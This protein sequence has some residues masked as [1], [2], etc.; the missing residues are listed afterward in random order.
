MPI[1]IQ[2]PSEFPLH[3]LSDRDGAI[4]LPSIQLVPT[5]GS[6]PYLYSLAIT[7]RGQPSELAA[8]IQEAYRGITR[9][10][11]PPKLLQKTWISPLNSFL[12][13]QPL[14][15]FRLGVNCTLQVSVEYC[16]SDRRGKPNQTVRNNIAKSCVLW[17]L[18][19]INSNNTESNEVFWEFVVEPEAERLET[20][21]KPTS[22]SLDEEV[23]KQHSLSNPIPPEPKLM[24]PSNPKEN[25]YPGFLAI[26]F[27]TSNSTV[28]LFDLKGFP[29]QDGLPKE[30]ENRLQER[31]HQWLNSAAA[32]IPGINANEWQKF[33][34]QISKMLEIDS[35]K[36]IDTVRD[37]NGNRIFLLETLRQ[38]ELCLPNYSEAFRRAVT[39]KISEIYAEAF[40]IPPLSSQTLFPVILN[41]IRKQKEICSELEIISWNS[42]PEIIMGER[43]KQDRRA[44]IAQVNDNSEPDEWKEIEGRFH[45]SPKRY[46][47]QDRSFEAIFNGEKQIISAN[48]L[49]QAT[50]GELIQLTEKYRQSKLK[51]FATGSF[52]TAVVTY[53]T[54]ASPLVRR[55]LEKIIKDLGLSD[56]ETV[57]D[58]A[59]AVAIFYLWREFGGNLNF[60]IESFKTRCHYDG[61]KWHQNLLAIDIGGGTTDI[62]LIRLTLKEIDPFEPHED[63]G[64]GGRYYV[65]TPKILGSSGHPQLGGELITLR[66]FRLLKVALADCLLTAQQEG[67]LKS[68]KLEN[69]IYELDERFLNGIQ[70]RIGSLL[71]C[72][73]KENPEGDAAYKDALNAAEKVIP[74]QWKDRPH[75]LQLFYAI[76]DMAEEIKLALGKHFKDQSPSAKYT[77]DEQKISEVLREIDQ[78]AEINNDEALRVTLHQQQFERIVTPVI[79]EAISIAK[80]LFE[81]R[82]S[83]S[84]LVNPNTPK[85][86]WLILSGQTSNLPQVQ[87]EIYSTFSQ[88]QYFVWNPERIAF[89]PEFAKLATSIGA[90]LAEKIRRYGFTSSNSKDMLIKGANQLDIEIKNLFYFLPCSFILRTQTED[91]PIT[92]FEAGKNLIQLDYEET[93]KARTKWMGIQLATSVYRLD[94]DRGERRNWGNFS[95]KGL[96]DALGMNGIDFRKYIQAQFEI[97]QKLQFKLF[98][99][100][101]NPHYLILNNIPALNG[102]SILKTLTQNKF[103]WKKPVDNTKRLP[104][105]GD[106]AVNVLEAYMVDAHDAYHLVFEAD[107]DVNQSLQI[108]HYEG[109]DRLG[110]GLISNPLPSFPKI[111]KHTFYLFQGGEWKLIGELS[112]PQMRTEFPYECRVTLDDKGILRIHAGEVPYCISDDRECLKE[113]GYVFVTELEL[114]PNEL[115]RER[116]PF[117][118]EH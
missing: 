27:G 59:V 114:Q 97:N 105:D 49:I 91:N 51:E 107:E 55:D 6:Q 96:A 15:Q 26:D 102:E 24:S 13:N 57:Y 40:R 45:H 7:V 53:P 117:S 66:L 39:K 85:I 36:L 47:G 50:Y 81:N 98:L 43:A 75:R 64:S 109:D 82:L 78:D 10:Y 52:N 16:E 72:L 20:D 31:V 19:T 108:F 95:G 5:P 73:D 93:V 54:V 30:Q 101:G 8:K 14:N 56:V 21:L 103:I 71:E 118:G 99:C 116:D 46:F 42:S 48:E 100:R 92:L 3:T 106:I 74:T 115:I 80:E 87:Q 35:N 69:C 89:V 110:K 41:S 22:K 37:A 38:F 113:E 83:N 60:G 63:R 88:S 23:F 68:R 9:Q 70:F 33:L 67:S 18:P 79:Q 2:L 58:E 90:C 32:D 44:A 34:V 12:L 29:H 86:D 84:D 94:Y 1:G 111:G 62:V 77:V 25:T 4:A 11:K 28:T 112:Q 65:L 76:W 17:W 104:Q 61:D